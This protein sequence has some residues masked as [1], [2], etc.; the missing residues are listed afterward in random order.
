MKR[1]QNLMLVSSA[2]GRT[3]L[4]AKERR[5]HSA[6]PPPASSESFSDEVSREV[7]GALGLDPAHVRIVDHDPSWSVLY[8]EEKGRIVG[9]IGKQVLGIEHVGSTAVAGLPAKPIIDV[10]V[11]IRS[12]RTISR[13]TAALLSLNYRQIPEIQIPGEIFFRRSD[14]AYHLHLLEYDSDAWINYLRFRNHLREHPDAA[15]RYSQLKNSLAAEFAED[16]PAYTRGKAGFIQHMLQEL[17][18]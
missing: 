16:R 13:L 5:T 11:A 9:A 10:V 12:L 6:P 17:E 2:E 14:G 4:H 8:E 15:S 1:P 3:T 18:H 7:S